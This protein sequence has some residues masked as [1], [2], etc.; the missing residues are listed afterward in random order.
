MKFLFLKRSTLWSIWLIRSNEYDKY[1][2]ISLSKETIPIT[3]E[4]YKQ[5]QTPVSNN[6]KRYEDRRY[7]AIEIIT[8]NTI[9]Y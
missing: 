8:Y 1:I 6:M 7:H 3:F 9:Y 5:Q 2:Y 4:K